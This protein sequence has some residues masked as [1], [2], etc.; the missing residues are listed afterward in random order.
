M[1][2]TEDKFRIG[3]EVHAWVEQHA[4]DGLVLELGGGNGSPH[5]HAVVKNCI[6]IESEPTW[7]DMLD[8]RGVRY[9]YAPLVDGWYELTEELTELLRTADIVIIDGPVGSLRPNCEQH[10]HHMK[11]GCYVLFDDTHRNHNLD[12]VRRCYDDGWLMVHRLTC[13]FGRHTHILQTPT[14]HAPPTNEGHP[15]PMEA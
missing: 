7:A 13:P 12:I 8:E 15:H 6:T 10:L 14:Q 3:A 9:L 1:K 2:A 4:G 11:P 5:L